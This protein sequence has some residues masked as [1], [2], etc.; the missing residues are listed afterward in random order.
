MASIGHPSGVS[1]GNVGIH[2]SMRE[3][4]PGRS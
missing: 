3:A 4:R 2:D 1:V